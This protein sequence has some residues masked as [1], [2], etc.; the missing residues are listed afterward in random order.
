MQSPSRFVFLDGYFILLGMGSA[1]RA[2]QVPDGDQKNKWLDELLSL[3][4]WYDSL[5]D[6]DTEVLCLPVT[7]RSCNMLNDDIHHSLLTLQI[8]KVMNGKV[9]QSS[10]S[11]EHLSFISLYRE[12]KFP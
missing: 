5:F 3:V 12:G 7:Q 11:C 2:D 9:R 10:A 1:S 4:L 8:C 6:N